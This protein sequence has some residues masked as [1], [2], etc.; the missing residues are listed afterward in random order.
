MFGGRLYVWP[1]NATNPLTSGN[2]PTME[3]R[4]A[5]LLNPYAYTAVVLMETPGETIDPI[6][7]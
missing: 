2:I 3:A 7:V 1:A 6:I 4:Y 5:P